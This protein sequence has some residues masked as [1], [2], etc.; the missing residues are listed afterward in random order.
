MT[1]IWNWIRVGSLIHSTLEDKNS[2][3]GGHAFGVTMLRFN[4]NDLV[5][6]NIRINNDTDLSF[7][8]PLLGSD[9]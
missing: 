6:L 7:G 5:D 9:F 3:G 8:P 1:G 2:G 4:R